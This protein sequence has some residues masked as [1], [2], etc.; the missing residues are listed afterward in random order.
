M[1][2]FALLIVCAVS[3]TAKES[4]RAGKTQEQATSQLQLLEG[5]KAELSFLWSDLA[6]AGVVFTIWN[7]SSRDT[8]FA[9]KTTPLDLS[10]PGVGGGPQSI[11]LEV[12]PTSGTIRGNSVQ[13]FTV[14][15][16]G[17][18]DPPG[19]A[20]Y[21]ALVIVEDTDPKVGPFVQ[22]VRINVTGPISAVSKFTLTAWHQIPFSTLWDSGGELPLTERLSAAQT[23]N[24][25]RIV[26]IVHKSSGGAAEVRWTTSNTPTA[27][28]QASRACLKIVNLPAAGQYDGEI[29]LG[30]L[31]I[32]QI[33]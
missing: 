27:Q 13:Q 29:W 5:Q 8:A 23:S 22:H 18:V 33:R 20:S 7:G 26:G 3:A 15:V 2:V 6:K 10:A 28:N 30:G 9:A 17:S 19:H 21:A 14:K 24:R 16:K 32:G 1:V 31:R 12:A 4:G 25:D 11:E